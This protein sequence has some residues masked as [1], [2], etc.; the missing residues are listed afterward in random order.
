VTGTVW[1]L[2]LSVQ[3][4]GGLFMK[5]TRKH[6]VDV[7]DKPLVQ[8]YWHNSKKKKVG[9]VGGEGENNDIGYEVQEV[10]VRRNDRNV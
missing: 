3:T 6:Y 9:F 8:A 7:R 10:Q 1:R 2:G 5:A 4:R